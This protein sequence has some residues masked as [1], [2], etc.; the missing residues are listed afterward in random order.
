[1]PGLETDRGYVQSPGVDGS[2]RRGS[3]KELLSCFLGVP[4]ISILSR[5]PDLS[6]K[7]Q[8]KF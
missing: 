1:M 5:D 4:A 7:P 2:I 8:L 6:R 3:Q